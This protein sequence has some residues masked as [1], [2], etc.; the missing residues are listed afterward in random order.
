MFENDVLNNILKPPLPLP[1]AFFNRG[2]DPYNE[3]EDYFFVNISQYAFLGKKFQAKV[4][5]R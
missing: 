1:V 2:F 4:I 5:P 3:F